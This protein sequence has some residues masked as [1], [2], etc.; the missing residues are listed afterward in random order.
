MTAICIISL[1]VLLSGDLHSPKILVFFQA[2]F[3]AAC[4]VQIQS[5]KSIDW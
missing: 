5:Q 1:S 2:S 4:E 3:Q